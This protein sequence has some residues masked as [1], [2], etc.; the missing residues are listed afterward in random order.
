MRDDD[1][2]RDDELP[3]DDP[4]GEPT[5]PGTTSGGGAVRSG[6]RVDPDPDD[7]ADD[8]D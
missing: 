6:H 8:D 2:R 5:G 1:D 3:S 4:N 7:A